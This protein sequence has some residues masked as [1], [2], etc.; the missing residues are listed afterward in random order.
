MCR[1]SEGPAHKER[2]FWFEKGRK[3]KNLEQRSLFWR[4]RLGAAGKELVAG[5][6]GLFTLPTAPLAASANRSALEL[7]DNNGPLKMLK[8]GA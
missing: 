2:L 8:S 3:K 1:Q 6:A 4:S 7:E 5:R